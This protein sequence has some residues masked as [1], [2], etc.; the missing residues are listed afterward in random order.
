MAT[1]R[2]FSSVTSKILNTPPGHLSSIPTLLVS[3]RGL[4]YHLF[5]RAYPDSRTPGSITVGM[6]PILG[7][8]VPVKVWVS[9]H[10]I[11]LFKSPQPFLEGGAKHEIDI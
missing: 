1:S 9:V 2:L 7:V 8:T 10:K 11:L 3:R 4:K 5:S 6:N